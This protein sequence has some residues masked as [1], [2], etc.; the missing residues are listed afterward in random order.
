MKKSS[1]KD[2]AKAASV[3]PST[4]DRVLN[5]RGGVSPDKEKRV[6]EWARKLKMDRALNQRV[7]RTLR[8]AVLIQPP[9]NPFHG[10]MQDAFESANRLFPQFN[11]QFRI[12]HINPAQPRGTARLV[13]HLSADYQGIVISAAHHPEILSAISMI[14][15]PGFPVITLVTDMRGIE[16]V[17]YIGPDNR[18]AGRVAGELMGRL[19]GNEGG[20]IIVVTG[21][22]SML[23]HE[24]REMGFRSV[25][26]E[27]FPNCSICAVLESQESP[28]RAGELVNVV[29]SS[30]PAVRGIYNASAGARPVV[31]A[32]KTLASPDRI[33]FITH[34]LTDER[35]SLL[36]QGLID[37]IIDQNPEL[38]VRR[39]VEYLAHFF[40][41][42]DEAPGSM[43]T[44][45]SIHM[46][47]NC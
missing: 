26:R 16:G 35:R 22:L 20:D 46:R 9:S 1:A 12:F 10:R 17:T 29:L 37:V 3:S 14:M 42:R 15:R 25:L 8:I 40:G 43:I 33:T 2:V 38:E 39:T 13:D 27:R 34:E 19:I 45:I 7:A 11:L 36:R 18:K 4:V 21:L 30:N 31:E 44:P 23:G 32:I 28:E 41:R 47:E 6:L 24:E 5:N